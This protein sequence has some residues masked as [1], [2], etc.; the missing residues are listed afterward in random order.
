MSTL[1]PT[2]GF[3]AG[4]VCA[5]AMDQESPILRQGQKRWRV[6]VVDSEDEEDDDD[7]TPLSVSGPRCC[8]MS[9]DVSPFT[10]AFVVRGIHPERRW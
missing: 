5:D 9:A 2:V 3:G 10:H 6:V 1:H 7:D 4:E 8:A